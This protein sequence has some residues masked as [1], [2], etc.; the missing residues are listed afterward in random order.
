MSNLKHNKNEVN[1]LRQALT[2]EGGGDNFDRRILAET[3]AADMTGV[4]RYKPTP[5]TESTIRA[6]RSIRAYLPDPVDDATVREI[7]ELAAL[8]PSGTNTQPWRVH[9]VSGAK[10][11]ALCDELV[12]AFLKG[13]EYHQ[14]YAYA[15]D[16]WPDIY[17]AR[18]RACG[19]GLYGTLG[20]VKGEKDKMQ[21]QHAR[22]FKFFDAPVGLFITIQRELEYGSWLDIGL[23]LQ[24]LM[25]AARAKGLDTCPQQA[26]AGFHKIIQ[27]RL[28][29]PAQE[30]VVCGVA[31]GYADMSAPEN[32]FQPAREPVDT[33]TVFHEDT[34]N[35]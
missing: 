22:N 30:M 33:F 18:R 20:I 9:V 17:Q 25:L 16:P 34:T 2:L 26:F 29:I 15:P 4:S 1:Q 24:N 35:E 27:Q 10:R 14:E 12:A 13:G 31:L 8:A 19:W 7:L 28:Q 23:F 6:R 5:E 3:D 21:A 11:D 32:R